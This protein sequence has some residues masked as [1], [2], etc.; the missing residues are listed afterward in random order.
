MTEIKLAKLPDRTP[1]KITFVASADLNQD[2]VDYAEA[3]RL[4]YG[5]AESIAELIPFILRAFIESDAGFKK[6]RRKRVSP[7]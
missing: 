7:T 2:L 1:A 4:R 5:S 6:L 3:Y